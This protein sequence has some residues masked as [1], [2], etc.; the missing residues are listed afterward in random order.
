MN[1]GSYSHPV[2]KKSQEFVPSKYQQAGYDW[3]D[4]AQGTDK[5]AVMQATAGSGKSTFLRKLYERSSHNYERMLLLCFNS[6]PAK[7]AREKNLAEM[8]IQNVDII[9]YHSYGNSAIQKVYKPK[10]DTHGEKTE[11]LVKNQLASN[12]KFLIYPIKKLVGLCKGNAQ[13]NPS[14]DELSELTMTYDI[15]FGEYPQQDLILKSYD[16]V[17]RTLQKS[18]EMVDTL[19]DFDDMIFIPNVLGLKPDKYDLILADEF[20][21]TCYAQSRLIQ[22]GKEGLLIGCGD[23]F[24]SIYGFRGADSHAMQNLITEFN[25]DTL[26]LSISYRCPL[27]VADLVRSEFPEIGFESPEWA[28]QGSVS[29]MGIEK[30]LDAM[31]DGDLVVSRV[32]AALPSIAFALIRKGKTA[33]IMGRD[34]GKALEAI[35]KKQNAYDIPELFSRLGKLRD[36]QFQ[37]FVAANRPDKIQQLDD[38]IETISALSE[39]ANT[40]GEIMTRCNTMFSDDRVGISLGTIHKNKGREADNVYIARPDLL[41]LPF[42]MKKGSAEDIQAERNCRYVAITRAKEN[43]V[44]LQGEL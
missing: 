13:P 23:K 38:Q 28:K 5:T 10:L 18:V 27:S 44:F 4:N 15:D 25:A 35:I 40:V 7:E 24:Q 11:T 12:Q 29:D 2:I 20:Q 41:P 9:T 8:N 17:R 31:Q 3:V 26:P 39:G 14:N 22:L 37:K 16:I 36:K 6:N 42:V 21:D 33:R 32:N 1:L 30:A 43:L 34:I 19:I